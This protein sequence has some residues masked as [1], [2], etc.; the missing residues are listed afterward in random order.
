MK[1]AGDPATKY[2]YVLMCAF[3]ILI[4][5]FQYFNKLRRPVLNGNFANQQLA[6]SILCDPVATKSV[7]RDLI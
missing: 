2:L 4:N 5:N 6:E 7:V 1:R 3:S